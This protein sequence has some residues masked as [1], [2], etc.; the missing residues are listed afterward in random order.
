MRATSSTIEPGVPYEALNLGASEPVAAVVARS[1][2]SEWENIIPYD[3]NAVTS[4]GAGP[5]VE[6]HAS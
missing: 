5:A 4:G 3:R 1:D 6:R 2:A